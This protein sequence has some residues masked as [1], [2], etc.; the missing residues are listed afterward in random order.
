MVEWTGSGVILSVR[1]HGET[2]AIIDVFTEEKG[3]HAGLVRGG[4]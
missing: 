3:R 4:V 1:K 2:S